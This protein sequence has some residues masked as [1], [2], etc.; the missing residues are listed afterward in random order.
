MTKTPGFFDT[1]RRPRL[2]IRAARFGL[3]NYRRERDLLRMLPQSR[4]PTPGR[5]ID[6]LLDV[7]SDM[8]SKRKLGDASYSVARHVDILIALMAES[9]YRRPRTLS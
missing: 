7:E 6:N 1:L 3:R 9:Q 2:L 8:E 4:L 5:A